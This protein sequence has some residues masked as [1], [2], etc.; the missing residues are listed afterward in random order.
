MPPPAPGFRAS[1]LPGGAACRLGPGFHG[2]HPGASASADPCIQRGA[3]KPP[4]DGAPGSQVGGHGVADPSQRGRH[5]VPGGRLRG[6]PWH[7]GP[8][9]G[10]VLRGLL[11][12]RSSVIPE[13]H[14]PGPSS[15][16]P[17]VLATLRS[18]G[19]RASGLVPAAGFF[20]GRGSAVVFSVVICFYGSYFSAFLF[21]VLFKVYFFWC[22]EPEVCFLVCD[23]PVFR[24]VHLENTPQAGT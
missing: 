24:S 17:S 22:L 7:W 14:R 1:A 13:Q 5:P 21:F 4:P 3:H 2:G 19:G 12:P 6:R 9:C 10:F 18:H 23:L 8:L 16:L 20:R 11:A 15:A